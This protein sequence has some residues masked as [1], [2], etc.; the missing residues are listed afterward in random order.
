M[1]KIRWYGLSTSNISHISCYFR[2]LYPLSQIFKVEFNDFSFKERFYSLSLSL[3]FLFFSP[4]SAGFRSGPGWPQSSDL[5]P[6]KARWGFSWAH[7]S[8]LRRRFRQRRLRRARVC[9]RRHL[10]L[11][12][13]ERAEPQEEEEEALAQLEKTS[14]LTS[15]PMMDF[16]TITQKHSYTWLKH[17]PVFHFHSWRF[18]DLII[19]LRCSALRWTSRLW[20][21]FDILQVAGDCWM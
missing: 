9:G 13:E 18:T 8:C 19:M 1:S 10:P 3:N 12:W 17:P 21:V 2:K 6:L 11:A 14:L 20:K 5:L 15:C 7:L 4:S 16:C